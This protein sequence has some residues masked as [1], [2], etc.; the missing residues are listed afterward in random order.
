MYHKRIIP[1]SLTLA[2]DGDKL[3]ATVASPIPAFTVCLCIAI[4]LEAL[5]QRKFLDP[6]G[7]QTI[8]R[9][10]SPQPIPAELS[11][12]HSHYYCWDIKC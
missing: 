4:S 3:H 9:L 8:S 7:N 1:T 6:A 12:L 10:Y 5:E 2:K 11:R